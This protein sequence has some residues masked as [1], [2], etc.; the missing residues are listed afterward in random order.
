[1]KISSG[2]AR[3]S[4]GEIST[5]PNTDTFIAVEARPD[6]YVYRDRCTRVI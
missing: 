3:R 6:I 2:R 1:M 4:R 5:I